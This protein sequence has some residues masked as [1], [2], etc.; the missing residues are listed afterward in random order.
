MRRTLAL[1][2]VLLAFQVGVSPALAWTWPVDGPVLRPFAFDRE[3]PYAAGQ[4]RGIDI[5]AAAGRSVAAPASGTV[6][7]AG[8]VPGGGLSLAIR[9]AD[10]YSATLVHLAAIA[11]AR[12]QTVREGAAVGTVGATGEAELGRAHVHFGVRVAADEHGYVD[13]LLL[14][15]GQSAP[16]P[17]PAPAEGAKAPKDKGGA[18]P[19]AGPHSTS[20]KEE[21]RTATPVKGSPRTA[22]SAARERGIT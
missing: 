14:L 9:T 1:L 19:A 8:P 5:G 12:G 21:A 20:A 2:P 22:D 6:T 7:F 13:P 16:P 11:V 15:S 10:G 3:S 18:T 4:H 17:D